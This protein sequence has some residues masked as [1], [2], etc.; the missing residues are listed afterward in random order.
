MYHTE[1]QFD[2]WLLD[3]QKCPCD[4]FDKREMPSERHRD[5]IDLLVIH[6][7]S[8]PPAKNEGDF[9]NCYVEDFFAGQLDSKCHP[10][11]AELEGIRVSSHLYIKRDGR[12]IQF[13]SLLDRAWHAGV[14]HFRGR[15]KCNEFS[16]GIEM[17]GTDAL[18]YTESQYQTLIKVTKEIQSYFPNI[19]IDNIVGHQHIAP[20]RKTDPGPSFD[21]Q[22]Y[23]SQL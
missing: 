23:K 11:F 22:K 13:V 8:L 2:G 5:G 12:L 16:I 21:W 10:I 18:P 17:Q 6:N 14:S 1:S 20:G 9:A 3:A 7:I 19:S 4:H 15:D